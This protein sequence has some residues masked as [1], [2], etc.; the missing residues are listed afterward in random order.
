[1]TEALTALKPHIAR[2]SDG[3]PLNFDEAREAFEKA[4]ELDHSAAREA[5]EKLREE[6]RL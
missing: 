2:V 1:M 3:Q 5:L 4:L 6:G